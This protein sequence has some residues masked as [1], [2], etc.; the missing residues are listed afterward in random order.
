MRKCV[1]GLSNFNKDIHSRKYSTSMILYNKVN[2][3]RV[4]FSLKG[5]IDIF[6]LGAIKP[7]NLAYLL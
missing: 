2:T 1:N 3:K 6:Q 5:G 4:N 7:E